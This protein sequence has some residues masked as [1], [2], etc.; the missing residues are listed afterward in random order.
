MQLLTL[1]EIRDTLNNVADS[2]QRVRYEGV[3]SLQDAY[4]G[5][6]Q[7][8]GNIQILN[9]VVASLAEEI[10]GRQQT[11]SAASDGSVPDGIQQ[12]GSADRR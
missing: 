9:T 12:G 11:G 5:I 4:D 1:A 10:Y 7:L 2:V 6:N 3:R 8:G